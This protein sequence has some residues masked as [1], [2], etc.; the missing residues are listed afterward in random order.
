MY[1]ILRE[2]AGYGYEDS[3][4]NY[5]KLAGL[6][7]E[8]VAVQV[9]LLNTAH[10]YIVDVIV[11][12]LGDMTLLRIRDGLV[13]PATGAWY[14]Q[15]TTNG[16]HENRN[17]AREVARRLI[18]VVMS[19]AKPY[20]PGRYAPLPE[21]AGRLNGFAAP[22]MV[23]VASG[24]AAGFLTSTQVGTVTLAPSVTEELDGTIWQ[25]LLFTATAL[26]GTAR[27][28][29]PNGLAAAQVSMQMS[30]WGATPALPVLAGEL[31]RPEFD[32]VIDDGTGGVP[33]NVMTWFAQVSIGVG[34]GAFY[35]VRPVEQNANSAG[36]C[37][38]DKVIAGKVISLP[39]AMPLNSADMDNGLVAVTVY[40]NDLRPV[41]IRVSNPR[42]VKY[43]AAR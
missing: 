22:A 16:L 37:S 31:V 40:T 36:L 27:V 41:R 25:D 30:T 42:F 43:P 33:T 10:R 3:T 28:G 11:P 39:I 24:R 14:P 15:Y 23:T 12:T 35:R 6:T 38:P 29:A 13:N 7:P 5:A 4:V 1:P 26:D 21:G 19:M 2:F 32:L 18:A 17:G 8:D 34:A 9:A 20:E